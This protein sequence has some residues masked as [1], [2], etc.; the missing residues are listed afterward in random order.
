MSR[1]HAC[2]NRRMYVCTPP[3]APFS[4]CKWGHPSGM[5]SQ[6][7]CIATPFP[8]LHAGVPWAPPFCPLPCPLSA[9]A[10]MHTPCAPTHRH[11]PKCIPCRASAPPSPSHPC[12]WHHPHALPRVCAHTARACTLPACTCTP[13]WAHA[14]YPHAKCEQGGVGWVRAG[15][16][17]RE[18]GH[19][20]ARGKGVHMQ[21]GGAHARKWRGAHM[22]GEG[23]HARE[24]EGAS[25]I[26]P[27]WL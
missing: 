3:C 24:G 20:C 6:W 23:A 1:G 14:P 22:Q 5:Q 15:A 13:P 12:V 11:R 25:A 21:E 27:W 8:N 17:V 4:P 18:E 7:Q 10:L 16:H 9:F 2:T 19:A 26:K